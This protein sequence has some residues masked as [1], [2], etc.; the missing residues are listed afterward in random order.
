M[1]LLCRILTVKLDKLIQYSILYI[2]DLH[3]RCWQLYRIHIR[4]EVK[5]CTVSLPSVWAA[6]DLNCNVMWKLVTWSVSN[7]KEGGRM[8]STPPN[9]PKKQT[10]LAYKRWSVLWLILEGKLVSE[11]DK[12]I[13]PWFPLTYFYCTLLCSCL[14]QISTSSCI[15]WCLYSD[16]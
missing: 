7:V 16:V 11:L 3:A 10:I 1:V 13:L 6:S 5:P 2:V 14:S 8:L 9:F 15:V 12:G 4:P